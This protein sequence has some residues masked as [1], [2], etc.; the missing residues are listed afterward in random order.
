T[1]ES[2]VAQWNGQIE[3]NTHANLYGSYTREWVLYDGNFDAILAT[4]PEAAL[5]T[6]DYYLQNELTLYLG[7]RNT[8]ENSS[9]YRQLGSIENELFFALTG[10][11]RY[12]IH[13]AMLQGSIIADTSVFTLEPVDSLLFYGARAFWRTK[14]MDFQ[15]AYLFS[16]RRA[17]STGTHGFSTL[18]ISRNF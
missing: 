12:V 11:Y 9:A 1:N 14:R 3:N 18:S 4:Q 2:Q 15:V 8:L 7:K 16:T 10:T 5:G 17:E 13:D 6:K